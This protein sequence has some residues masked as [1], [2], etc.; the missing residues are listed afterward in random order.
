MLDTKAV[1]RGMLLDKIKKLIKAQ[2]LIMHF[3]KIRLG[4]NGLAPLA[5]SDASQCSHFLSFE[6]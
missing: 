1:E 2:N 5:H 6:Q 3:L 4:S